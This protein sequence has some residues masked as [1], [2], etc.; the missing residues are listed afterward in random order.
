MVSQENVSAAQEGRPLDT[1][2]MY[3]RLLKP[4]GAEIALLGEDF[5]PPDITLRGEVLQKIKSFSIM[6][7][8]LSSKNIHNIITC[9]TQNSDC[10]I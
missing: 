7:I 9:M 6:S 5:P 10:V 2:D 4:K 8:I 3:G 1:T